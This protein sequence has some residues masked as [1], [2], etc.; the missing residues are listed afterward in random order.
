MDGRYLRQDLKTHHRW[1]HSAPNERRLSEQDGPAGTRRILDP[2]H[3]GEHHRGALVGDQGTN[4]WK[5]HGRKE[6]KSRPGS[7]RLALFS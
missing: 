7:P 3:L 2:K 4:G 1:N 6:G 5:F